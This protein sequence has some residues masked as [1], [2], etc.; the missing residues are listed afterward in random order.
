MRKMLVGAEDAAA[1]EEYCRPFGGSLVGV[2]AATSLIVHEIGDRP[3]YRTVVPFHTRRTSQWMD[4]V[5]WYVGGAPLEIPAAQAPDF[6]SLL[7]MVSTALRAGRPLSRM[8]IARV[9]RLLGSDF[10]PTSP[11]LY[12]IVSFVDARGIP[13]S[14]RR[15]ELKAYGLVRV[16]YGDQVCAWI[17]RLHEGLQ[18]ASRYPGTDIAYKNMRLYVERLRELIV[19]VPRR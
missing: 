10:R 13:G 8:P 3:V 5:G 12:S 2:L 6:P 19:G 9:L 4:S 11:D 18:F 1:F 16:S 15:A 17:N 7:R 14:E